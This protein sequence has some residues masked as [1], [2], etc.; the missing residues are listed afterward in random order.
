MAKYLWTP[1]SVGSA[2]VCVDTSHIFHL[3][4]DGHLGCF[5]VLVIVKSAAMNFGV[6]VSFQISVFTFS[7]YIPR[8]GIVRS[9]SSQFLV[10]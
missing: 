9:Y 10:F 6:L 3:S 8:S 7:R 2:C 5:C 4:V 1:Y